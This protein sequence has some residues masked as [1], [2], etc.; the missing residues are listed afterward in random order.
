MT[1]RRESPI[2]AWLSRAP[3][4][5]FALYATV[6]AFSCYLCMYAFRKP[7]A[8]AKFADQVL[9]GLDAKTVFLIA[10]VLGYAASK[11]LGIKIVSEL[12]SKRRA[13]S[14]L[15][16]MG[17]AEV[18]LV[19]FGALPNSVAAIAMIGNGLSLGMIWGMVFGFL[20]GRRTSDM[21]G[22]GLCASFIV[23]SGVAK[24]AGVWLLGLGVTEKWMPAA[25]GLLFTAPMLL[26]IYLLAQLPPPT[27]ADQEL[28]VERAPMDGP[29][30]KAFFGRYAT[31]LV[32]LVGAYV[33]LTALRDFRDN[34]SVEIWQA[35]GY[36]DAP[37][38]LTTTEIPVAVVALLGVAAMGVFRSN[39]RALLAIHGLL[40]GGAIIVG[41]STLAFR[42]GL[43]GPVAWMIT[44][45][46]GLYV[47]YV[48]YN[49]ILFD[50]LVAAAGS[51]ANAGFLIYVAD[52][53]GYAGSVVTQLYKSLGQKNLS[54]VSFLETFTL[55]ASVLMA[56][57]MSAS[58]AYFSRRIAPVEA[59]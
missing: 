9:L 43:I 13:R 7:I 32:L 44:L 51:K 19:L 40:V 16:C 12:D 46:I 52:A 58:A 15:L 23:G 17:A 29:A 14:I 5:V 1:A 2:H 55:V 41:I 56:I 11:F 18:S 50:R 34:F 54:W 35:L 42:A 49:C 4:N 59:R 38:I 26:C 48:P 47:A 37:A 33:L 21:L 25:T 30:R 27:A 28:R 24:S 10:Q 39:R 31:G 57:A 8:A 36:K 3:T 45:G 6:A 20:E 22:A 53:S